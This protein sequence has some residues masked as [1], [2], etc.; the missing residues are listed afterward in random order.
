MELERRF[1]PEFFGIPGYL[2]RG[3]SRGIRNLKVDVALAKM[4]NVETRNSP[5]RDCCET[6]YARLAMG[7]EYTRARLTACR[8]SESVLGLLRKS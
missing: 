4:M 2:T 7:Y 6:A 5:F 3:G 8:D 1:C